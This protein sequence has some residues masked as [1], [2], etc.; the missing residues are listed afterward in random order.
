VAVLIC[1]RSQVAEDCFRIV[2][3]DNDSIPIGSIANDSQ[4]LRRLLFQ[5]PG[6]IG[7]GAERMLVIQPASD[8]GSR[9]LNIFCFAYFTRPWIAG[10]NNSSKSEYYATKS[11]AQKAGP[12]TGLHFRFLCFLKSLDLTVV[13]T[14]TMI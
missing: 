13:S 11:Q 7:C 1:N 5:Q 8:F 10:V 2:Q 3:R 9:S 12:C 4:E 14:V 6:N